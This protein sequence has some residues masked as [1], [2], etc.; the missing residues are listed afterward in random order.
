LG[1]ISLSRKKHLA[2]HLAHAPTL[3]AG[4]RAVPSDGAAKLPRTHERMTFSP[5]LLDGVNPLLHIG[6]LLPPQ[7]SI[8]TLESS[9]D[10]A[11]QMLRSRIAKDIRRHAQKIRLFE[12][13]AQEPQGDDGPQPAVLL[14]PTEYA[15]DGG[16]SLPLPD[17]SASA[18]PA[19]PRP[20]RGLLLSIAA[21]GPEDALESDVAHVAG[22]LLAD[23]QAFPSDEACEERGLTAAELAAAVNPRSGA[24]EVG[25]GV[26]PLLDDSPARLLLDAQLSMIM[27]SLMEAPRKGNGNVKWTTVDSRFSHRGGYVPQRPYSAPAER[28]FRPSSSASASSSSSSAA[29]SASEQPAAASVPESESAT[30]ADT[31]MDLPVNTNHELY[32]E[33]D[34]PLC[35]SEIR[36]RVQRQLYNSVE[37]IGIDC[38]TMLKE[39]RTAFEG[40]APVLSDCRSLTKTL[41]KALEVARS[42]MRRASIDSSLL[43]PAVVASSASSVVAAGQAAAKARQSTQQRAN[44]AIKAAR[45]S[46]SASSASSSS[47]SSRPVGIFHGCCHLCNKV[48]ALRKIDFSV[49]RPMPYSYPRYVAA[50]VKTEAEARSAKPAAASVERLELLG[51]KEP[52]IAASGA[53]AGRWHAPWRC[54]ECTQG[55]LG[56]RLL[57]DRVWVY[58]E[59]NRS[60][61]CGTV[62]AFE[63]CGGQYR[64]LY[65]DGE[66]EILNLSSVWTWW[67]GDVGGAAP[68]MHPE[69]GEPWAPDEDDV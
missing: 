12:D 43:Q 16:D 50:A 2:Q 24:P 46:S 20:A 49:P 66:W 7:P 58:W 3:P 25:D 34:S 57:G 54:H 23:R 61:F 21:D 52:A 59:G 45:S 68:T 22:A 44:A 33:S 48:Y 18:V 55:R 5:A 67:P 65:E 28:R 30:A 35:L 42:A 1:K 4:G 63:R 64:V 56:V 32:R 53:V 14:H 6:A 10:N 15:I 39:Y 51:E 41:N 36:R 9:A 19:I 69:T 11:V 29:A 17:L 47:S 60:W 62:T 27:K 13:P 38:L 37:E 31:F 40:Y 8:S 26:I